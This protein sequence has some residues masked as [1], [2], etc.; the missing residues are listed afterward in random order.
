MAASLPVHNRATLYN[1][2]LSLLLALLFWIG[3][4]DDWSEWAQRL[5]DLLPPVPLL[6]FALLLREI[7]KLL[8]A[9]S[10]PALRKQDSSNSLV[11]LHSERPELV[12][13]DEELEKL[14]A[15]CS[16]TYLA[17][18][19]DDKL[20]IVFL[21][22]PGGYGKS[23]LADEFCR[24]HLPPGWRAG[25]VSEVEAGKP[26]FL[27]QHSVVIFDYGDLQVGKLAACLQQLERS[28]Q[29]SGVPLRL[30]ALARSFSVGNLAYQ[31]LRQELQD[32]YNKPSGWLDEH[33]HQPL[34]LPLPTLTATKNQELLENILSNRGA[35]DAQKQWA[36]QQLTALQEQRQGSTFP[37]AI[38]ML[39]AVALRQGPPA[40]DATLDWQQLLQSCL[41]HEQQ[42]WWAT[43]TNSTEREAIKAW[44]FALAIAAGPYSLNVNESKELSEYLAPVLECLGAQDCDPKQYLQRYRAAQGG[45]CGLQPDLLAEYFAAQFY[46]AGQ[47]PDANLEL[48]PKYQQLL[49]SLLLNFPELSFSFSQRLAQD[50][51]DS[52]LNQSLAEMEGDN[53]LAVAVRADGARVSGNFGAA[54]Q[55]LKRLEELGAHGVRFTAMLK[56]NLINA[57]GRAQDFNRTEELYQ[58]LQGLSQ[59]HPD[60]SEI[61]LRQARAA[62]AL[63]LCNHQAQKPERAAEYHQQLE[64]LWAQY[65][66][67]KAEIESLIQAMQTQFGG[68]ESNSSSSY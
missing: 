67:V 48:K 39:A 58:Q 24:E 56:V 8:L 61:V 30:I 40:S 46:A 16:P 68:P 55:G 5:S 13:R 65:P 29:L 31:A 15:F 37:L 3:K 2:V 23:R 26:Y 43:E 63:T 6:A 38:Y 49:K 4:H 54:E 45:M 17:D 41:D 44:A 12:G 62:L 20:K 59:K 50:F 27:A 57:Y 7:Q 11:Y 52:A 18:G 22:A 32:K 10:L 9:H 14:Q 19:D 64:Q 36:S 25:L 51:P 53:P 66:A 21:V 28:Q 33:C 34:C 47:Y 35:D 1:L 60:N 42:Q